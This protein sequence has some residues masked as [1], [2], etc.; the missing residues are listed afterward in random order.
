MTTAV[1]VRNFLLSEL[2]WDETKG[3]L[4][5]EFGL[6]ENHVVDSMGLLMLVSFVEQQF[7]IELADE[8]LVPAHFGTIASIASLVD[9][10]MLDRGRAGA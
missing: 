8:E 5:P 7:G 6:I 3:A 4:T 1:T 9:K 10:K 2:H